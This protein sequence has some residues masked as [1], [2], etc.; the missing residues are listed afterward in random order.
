MRRNREGNKKKKIIGYIAIFLMFGSVFGFIFLGFRTGG[1]FLDTVEYNDFEF[2]SR[3][4]HWSTTIDGTDAPF[5]YLPADVELLLIQDNAINRL[6][7]VI[8]IDATYDFNDTFAESIALAQ[9]QMGT[10]LFNF[11]IFVRNGFTSQYQNFPVITCKDAT[12][13]VPVIYF[14]ESNVT[15][16]HMENNCIIAE[17]A[18]AA[19]VIRLKDRLVYG[20]LG[21][22]KT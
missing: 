22:I 3:G 17:A 11:N 4:T 10:T 1:Q 18:N 8:E 14:K 6:K 16:A 9:F 5:S 19:D 20:I 15:N 7:G 21:I 12:R 2:A 13:F